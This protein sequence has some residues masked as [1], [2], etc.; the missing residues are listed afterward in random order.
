MT[1]L[2]PLAA[3]VEHPAPLRHRVPVWQ[4]IAGLFAAPAAW[5]AQLLVSYGLSGDRCRPDVMPGLGFVVTVISGLAV[6]VCLFGIWSAYRSWRLT[7]DEGPGDHHAGLTA[8]IGRTRFLALCGLVGDGIFL[9]A[10]LFNFL[11][12][13]LV[14]P[15]GF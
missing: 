2:H 9:I 5:S 10:T 11:V 15:C 1:A 6:A 12:P 14:S 3:G 4:L 13:L 8:G 7:R